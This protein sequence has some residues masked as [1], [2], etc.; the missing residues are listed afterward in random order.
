MDLERLGIRPTI[1]RRRGSRDERLE[2]TTP[3]FTVL[4]VM[5]QSYE[6]PPSAVVAELLPASKF[7]CNTIKRRVV[8]PLSYWSL[9]LLVVVTSVWLSVSSLEFANSNFWAIGGIG[10]G[11]GLWFCIIRLVSYRLRDDRSTIANAIRA[12]ADRID[13]LAWAFVFNTC[14]TFAGFTFT[15]LATAALLPLQD[16]R[17]AVLDQMLGFDW[18]WFL[19]LTNSS[20]AV[21]SVLG[22]AYGTTALQLIMLYL[23]LS[24]S[25]REQRLAEFLTL[26]SV[27]FVAVCLLMLLVPA[28]GAYPYY[29]PPRALFDG[30]SPNAG[31]WHYKLFT[32]LRTQTAIVLDFRHMEGLVTFPSFH[33]VLAIITA[34]AV[35]GIRFIAVPVAILNGIVIVS[36]VPEGGHFLVDVIAGAIIA[37]AS[38]ALVRLQLGPLS[39]GA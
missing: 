19:A 39:R 38:I 18:L 35:R 21:S 9:G 5:N 27:T 8:T 31:M 29:R 30:F 26:Y 13:L 36:T 24:F 4:P 25:R 6:A 11:F 15:C 12:A 32:E 10:L 2:L 14:F 1:T 17:L 20:R 3:Y 34:Y 33:T 22:A 37:V 16:A 28:A 23:V 7:P